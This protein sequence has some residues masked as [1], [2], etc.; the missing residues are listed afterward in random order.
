MKI[1]SN[2]RKYVFL[3]DT[4]SINIE[5]IIKSHNFLKDTIKFIII[6]DKIEIVNYLKKIKSNLRINEIL[7]PIKFYN[8]KIKYLNIFLHKLMNNF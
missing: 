1:K 5:I 4:D 3:G 6:C 8:Y 2:N 7:D